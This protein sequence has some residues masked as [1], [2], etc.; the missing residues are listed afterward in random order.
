MVEASG[1]ADSE[2][3]LAIVRENVLLQL[4]H[5]RSYDLVREK[6]REGR[7]VLQGWVY[8]LETGKIEVYARRHDAWQAVVAG[9]ET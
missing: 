4:G 9:S 2:R 5:L 8:H 6:E 7:V 3:H 1:L